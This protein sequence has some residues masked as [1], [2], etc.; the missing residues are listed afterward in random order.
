[1]KIGYARV[2]TTDQ[3]LDMQIDLLKE[4]GCE[5][6]FTEKISGVAKKRPALE[7]MISFARQGD[8]IYVFKIDRLGRSLKHLVET[9]NTFKEKGIFFY[10]VSDGFVLNE[11]AT[12]QLMFNIFAAF[13]QFERDLI[14]ERTRIGLAA[15]R[16]RGKIGG[17]PKGLSKSAEDT[18]MLAE[19]L[20]KEGN[21]SVKEICEKLRISTSTLYKYLRF[22]NV[23]IGSSLESFDKKLN[24]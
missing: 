10:S 22:R 3:N 17:R 4:K 13:A 1:M 9:V 5:R 15:A 23:K 18:A 6:I 21:L 12:G 11:S 16:K 2:S 8:E 24:R 20:Y 7:D 19:V 14:S